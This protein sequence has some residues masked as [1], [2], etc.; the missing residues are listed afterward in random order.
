MHFFYTLIGTAVIAAVVGLV[1]ERTGFTR[2]GVLPSVI[3]C[4]GG[5]ML[6]FFVGSM[7]RIGFGSPGLNAVA[8]SIGALVIVPTHYRRR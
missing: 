5:A 6:F 3:I 7:F 4:I 1:S 2:N 8:A